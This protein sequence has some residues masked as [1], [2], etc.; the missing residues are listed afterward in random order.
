MT[1]VD[2]KVLKRKAKE[3]F[4]HINW[5]NYNVVKKIATDIIKFIEEKEKV[6]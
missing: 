2:E 1:K 4:G 3:L 6:K 5:G